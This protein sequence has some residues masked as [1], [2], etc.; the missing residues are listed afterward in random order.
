[1][2]ERA[3]SVALKTVEAHPG[4]RGHTSTAGREVVIVGTGTRAALET[5]PGLAEAQPSLTHIEALELDKIPEHLLVVGGG[6]VGVEMAQAKRR[7]GGKVT[8]VDRSGRLMSKKTPDVC[9]GLLAK[10][11]RI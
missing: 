9:E 6:Y 11:A 1:M 5:I 7:F 3:S 10:P 4:R 8:I 2:W